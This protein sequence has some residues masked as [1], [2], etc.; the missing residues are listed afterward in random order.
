MASGKGS[1]LITGCTTGSIGHALALEFQVQGYYVIATSRK[2]ETMQDLVQSNGI[3]TVSLDVCSEDS[4]A[5]AKKQI[6]V[7]TAGKLDYLVNNAGGDAGPA[8][9]LE[10]DIP[11]AQRTFDLNFWGTVRM[12]KAFTPLLMR[13]GA[14]HIV[15]IS[16]VT[17]IIP[18]PYLSVYGSAKAAL[19][20]YSD[21]LRV[22][23]TPF[24]ISVTAV[25]TGSISN[26]K[27]R[28]TDDFVLKLEPNSPYDFAK[29]AHREA[30]EKNAGEKGQ[31]P[32]A[33]Y[34]RRVVRH[35]TP[36]HIK[37]HKWLYVG[38]I[39]FFAWLMQVFF[40]RWVTEW[41]MTSMWGLD[42][43]TGVSST[44]QRRKRA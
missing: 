22:E 40:P 1:V 36:G 29:A 4:I 5:R 24:N 38:P 39:I 20:Q 25:I 34:A 35:V 32:A 41:I 42:K 33:E 9:A 15:N 16:S 3:E 23:L 7:L 21:V 30:A 11:R 43:P 6:E 10:M 17:G 37:P 31:M 2:L 27:N 19:N 44:K 8:P 26:S 28:T 18:I 13:S 14:G 12:V